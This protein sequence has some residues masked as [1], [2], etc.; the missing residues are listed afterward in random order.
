[1]STAYFLGSSLLGMVWSG[2]INRPKS[3]SGKRLNWL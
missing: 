1:M 2:G 3:L